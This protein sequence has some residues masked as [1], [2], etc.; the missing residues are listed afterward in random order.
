[1][2]G[3]V[4]GEDGMT[5]IRLGDDFPGSVYKAFQ[6]SVLSLMDRGILLAVCSKNDP[7]IVDR[8]LRD[9][10]E[11]LIRPDHISASRVG[12]GPKSRGLREI[13]AELG[14]GS[15]ALVLFDDNPV[16]RA[17]VRA[18][19]PEVGVVEMPADPLRYDEALWGCGF[20]DQL[21]LSDEDLRLVEAR[22]GRLLD[23]VHWLNMG[24]GHAITGERLYSDGR[25][26]I[27]FINL[28]EFSLVLYI[29]T[30]LADL[31]D[32]EFGPYPLTNLLEYSRVGSYG[33]DAHENARTLSITARSLANFYEY[34]PTPPVLNPPINLTG[35][36][37]GC[38]NGIET[39][40]DLYWSNDPGTTAEITHYE[41]WKS[42]PVGN[43]FVYGW[44]VYSAYTQSYVSGATA[45]ARVNA[46]SGVFVCSTRTVQT[47]RAAALKFIMVGGGI[48]RGIAGRLGLAQHVLL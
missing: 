26:W 2:F 6:R 7:D 27:N 34:P 42:Q 4:I 16:E 3:G 43:P 29:G 32:R 40:H 36:N 39:R 23:Q 44:T 28:P 14:I 22:F 45:R 12:W 11:M 46:C 31:S 19:A 18:N 33:D 20:F 15:D 21:A 47:S 25:A 37:F 17:E 10:P 8:V 48:V 5:G 9:H 38:V 1:M 24:G 35:V 30:A 41:I 13:A